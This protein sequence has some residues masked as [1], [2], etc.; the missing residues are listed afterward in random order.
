MAGRHRL[1]SSTRGV[2]QPLGE[3]VLGEIPRAVQK[4][5]FAGSNIHFSKQGREEG[6]NL[7]KRNTNLSPQE[8][9]GAESGW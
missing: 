1:M 9:P 7:G 2:V 5:A 8:S 6:G 4:G 3:Q